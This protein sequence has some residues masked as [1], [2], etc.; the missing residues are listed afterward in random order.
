[1]RKYKF[2]T[3]SPYAYYENLLED[4][5]TY[6]YK[7]GLCHSFWSSILEDKKKY[8]ELR[9]LLEKYLVEFNKLDPMPKGDK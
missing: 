5:D 3:N 9:E 7:E 4:I 6:L 2:L 1:M 8:V